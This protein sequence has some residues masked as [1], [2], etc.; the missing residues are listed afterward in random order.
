MNMSKDYIK[1]PRLYVDEELIGDAEI[2]IHDMQAHY[3]K[4]VLRKKSGDMVRIFNGRN[5]EWIAEIADLSKKKILIILREKLKEQSASEY[6]THLLFAPIKK[7]RMDILIEKAVELGAT[8]L[9]P[10]ITQNT[11]S[12]KINEDRI[13]A[14][15]IEAAEQCERLDLPLLHSSLTLDKLLGDWNKPQ[16]LFVALE[17]SDNA[18][19]LTKPSDHAFIL[20]GPEGGFTEKEQEQLMAHDAVST[21]SLGSR[22]L[23]AETAAL[24]ALSLLN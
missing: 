23:R 14:Q 16:T 9:H 21:I 19:R 20:I 6:K 8:D 13:R 10:I 1:C 18:L 4:N 17:R 5:G 15:I 22:V 2:I 12:R 7:N 3:L 11:E 24:K